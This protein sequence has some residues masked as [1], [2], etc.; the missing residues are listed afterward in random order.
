MADIVWSAQTALLKDYVDDEL[1]RRSICAIRP[2]CIDTP[3][4]ETGSFLQ[5]DISLVS[6]S[7]GACV[8][9]GFHRYLDSKEYCIAPNKTEKLAGQENFITCFSYTKQVIWDLHA[10][11]GDHY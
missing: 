5:L 11:A 1:E 2:I 10:R 4:H 3:T 6:Y 7:K 8:N 9:Q